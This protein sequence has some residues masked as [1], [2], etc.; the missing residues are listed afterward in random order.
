MTTLFNAED[1]RM[2]GLRKVLS[3]ISVVD[4]PARV[5]IHPPP[6]FRNFTEFAVRRPAGTWRFRRQEDYLLVLLRSSLILSAL[7]K[8]AHRPSIRIGVVS[9]GS[10]RN[11]V[12]RWRHD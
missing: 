1:R 10:S 5:S 9:K 2:A 6:F 12:R 11:H 8:E 4:S 7:R 3:G